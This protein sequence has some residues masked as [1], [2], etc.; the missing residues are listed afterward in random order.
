MDNTCYDLYHYQYDTFAWNCDR[1]AEMQKVM[2]PSWYEGIH[3]IHFASGQDD[4][5]I[6]KI[7]WSYSRDVPGLGETFTKSQ[8]G[9]PSC[10]QQNPFN[11]DTAR[12]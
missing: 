9:Q 1:K 4:E 5:K 2:F 3:K 7:I 8:D 11:S 10:W 6:D 12:I